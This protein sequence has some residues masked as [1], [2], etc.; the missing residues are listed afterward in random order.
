MKRIL[1]FFMVFVLLFNFVLPR[2]SE[3]VAPLAGAILVNPKT[4]VAVGSLLASVG[5]VYENR[6]SL[7]AGVNDFLDKSAQIREQVHNAMLI[8]GIYF[9]NGIQKNVFPVTQELYD[10]AID[11]ASGYSGESY[12]PSSSAV[13][14]EYIEDDITYSNLDFIVPY[15]KK[16]GI[17]TSAS[18]KS[19][20]N[21][22]YVDQETFIDGIESTSQFKEVTSNVGLTPFARVTPILN[23][24]SYNNSLGTNGI[25]FKFLGKD[26]EVAISYKRPN[27]LYSRFLLSGT[28]SNNYYSYSYSDSQYIVP[29]SPVYFSAQPV[30]TSDSNGVWYKGLKIY[31]TYIHYYNNAV[32]TDCLR[33][34]T[35]PLTNLLFPCNTPTGVS[36][37]SKY[38]NPDISALFT[39]FDE[40]SGLYM[41]SGNAIAP[42]VNYS[43]S[44]PVTEEWTYSADEQVGIVLPSGSIDNYV[45]TPESVTTGELTTYTGEKTG[46]LDWTNIPSEDEGEEGGGSISGE[47][48]IGKWLTGT[49]AGTLS[50]TLDNAFSNVNAKIDSLTN[51][52]TNVFNPELSWQNSNFRWFDFIILFLDVILA[53]IRLTIRFL[54]FVVTLTQIVATPLIS[55]SHMLQGIDFLKNITIPE[56]NFTIWGLLTSFATAMIGVSAFKFIK[57]KFRF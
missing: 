35:M 51:S 18:I 46:E 54:V 48:D 50:G 30:Y 6:E 8:S 27:G 7:I 17:T 5:I 25:K 39:T 45:G 32:S 36:D 9:V 4:Y 33:P 11:Y 44:T 3:A 2:R 56:T 15:D 29:F 40:A 47:F 12:I 42:T 16:L 21:M 19:N 28:S 10:S 52:L 49:G 26:V 55:N 38:N 23:D 31:A 22:I 13:L 37:D 14:T 1:S 34:Q 43:V 53:C 24:W 20:S 41:P 57:R